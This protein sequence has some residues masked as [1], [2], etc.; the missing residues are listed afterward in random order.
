M[1]NVLSL[2][3][4][5]SYPLHHNQPLQNTVD[6]NIHNLWFL[7]VLGSDNRGSSFVGLACSHSCWMVGLDWKVK[8]G[9]VHVVVLACQLRA[10]AVSFSNRLA[11]SQHSGLRSV[12]GWAQ[13]LQCFWRP[14]NLHNS[15]STTFHWSKQSTRAAQIPEARE[16]DP[17]TW[18]EQQQCHI[19]REWDA[20]KHNSLRVITINITI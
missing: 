7:T 4:C 9:L 15:P 8:C 16:E 18:W 17:T 12:R 20:G 2:F 13:K 5:I 19:A 1:G 11:G 6:W 10:S 14:R 3:G